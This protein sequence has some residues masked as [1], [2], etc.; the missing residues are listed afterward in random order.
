MTMH[1]QA[2]CRRLS[3]VIVW[4][5]ATDNL[6]SHHVK[7]RFGIPRAETSV[8]NMKPSDVAMKRCTALLYYTGQSSRCAD[9]E[10]LTHNLMN[11]SGIC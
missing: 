6:G 2:V 5:R 1:A 8:W 11:I 9:S 4:V 7:L 3:P 10:K